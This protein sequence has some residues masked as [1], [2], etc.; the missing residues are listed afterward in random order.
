M[1]PTCAHPGCTKPAHARGGGK[2]RR[3]CRRHHAGLADPCWLCG[4]DRASRDK[5]RIVGDK[6]GGRYTRANTLLVCP[7][8]HRV[9]EEQGP[10]DE[11]REAV[12]GGELMQ[13]HFID[14]CDALCILWDI[15]HP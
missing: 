11:I 5:H 7:N 13:E 12:L 10:W 3:Y 8:C 14:V 9:C 1:K 2:Y 6:F 4:W 15:F